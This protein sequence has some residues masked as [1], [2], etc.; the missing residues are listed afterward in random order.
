MLLLAESRIAHSSKSCSQNSKIGHKN[1]VFVFVHLFLL[2]CFWQGV[3]KGSRRFNEAAINWTVKH[4]VAACKN[5]K[6]DFGCK[7]IFDVC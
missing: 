1:I 4:S 2:I 3:C 5:K 7:G 6:G